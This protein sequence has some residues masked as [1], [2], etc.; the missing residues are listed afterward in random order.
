MEKIRNL[1]KLYETIMKNVGNIESKQ[2][3]G[4]LIQRLGTISAKL[5]QET[6]R[7]NPRDKIM[8]IC[9]FCQ[10]PQYFGLYS[11]YV[12]HVLWQHP[13]ETKRLQLG[14]DKKFFCKECP[15]KFIYHQSLIN[16]IKAKH[17]AQRT[18]YSCED[19]DYQ[20]LYPNLLERHRLYHCKP[21]SCSD[22]DSSSDSE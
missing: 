17:C 18:Y 7:R 4:V 15:Q 3:R 12:E 1:R 19:C 13:I 14:P 21:D 9:T 8:K 16:H 2:H 5:A 20:T 11:Q 10:S 22:S 6:M